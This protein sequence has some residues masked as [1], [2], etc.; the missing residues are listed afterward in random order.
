MW[1][2]RFGVPAC[3]TTHRGTQSTSGTWG[4]WCQKQWVQHITTKAYHPQ[5]NGMVERIHRTLKAALCTRGGAAAWKVHLPWVLLGMH[6]TTR[7]ESGVSV[8]EATLQQQLV[9]TGQLPPPSERPGGM[10]G[11]LA[12]IPPTVCSYA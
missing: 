12:V 4:D 11:P 7:E 5:A 8:A 2:A 1:V 10:E 6:A 9:V 3:I